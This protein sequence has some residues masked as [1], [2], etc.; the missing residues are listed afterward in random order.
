MFVKDLEKKTGKNFQVVHVKVQQPR[1][2]KKELP[3]DITGQ[4]SCYVVKDTTCIEITR[5]EEIDDEWGSLKSD[6]CFN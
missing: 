1:G 4:P 3:L 6:W 2:F 5:F